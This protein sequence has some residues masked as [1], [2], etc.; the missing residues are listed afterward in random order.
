MSVAMMA[1]ALLASATGLALSFIGERR[2]DLYLA[3]HCAAALAFLA[4]GIS[5]AWGPSAA[6]ISTIITALA[7]HWPRRP[8]P[9]LAAIIAL[10]AGVWSGALYSQT[11]WSIEWGASAL[12]LVAVPGRMMAQM[13]AVQAGIILKI[14]AGWIAA[15]AIL[16]TALPLLLTPGDQMDHRE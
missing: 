12:I 16:T 2:I 4:S 7:V 9:I 15:L 3:L 8:S 6:G 10:N 1:L 5:F 14:I 13:A 11:G